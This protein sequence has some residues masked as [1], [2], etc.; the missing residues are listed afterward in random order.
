MGAKAKVGQTVLFG[1]H[2]LHLCH[3]LGQ[4]FCFI[5]FQTFFCAMSWQSHLIFHPTFLILEESNCPHQGCSGKWLKVVYFC[6]DLRRGGNCLQRGRRWKK[7]LV[8]E[9]DGLKRGALYN[10]YSN[11]MKH[12]LKGQK[13]EC[14]NLWSNHINIIPVIHCE[15]STEK[16]STLSLMV[17][18][19]QPPATTTS[20]LPLALFITPCTTSKTSPSHH[21]LAFLPL[22]FFVFKEEASCAIVSTHN[23]DVSA[24]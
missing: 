6:S 4:R 21:G 1:E 5:L 7:Q 23:K 14:V 24:F 11:F 15:C 13:R 19:F 12:G 18:L 16:I 9:V 20:S 2:A 10:L 3:C 22:F 8:G 17:P